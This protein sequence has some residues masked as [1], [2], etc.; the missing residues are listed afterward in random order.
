MTTEQQ[1]EQ[2]NPSEEEAKLD[3]AEGQPRSRRLA[4]KSVLTAV[5]VGVV[6]ISALSLSKIQR[7]EKPLDELQ[8]QGFNT[9][10]REVIKTPELEVGADEDK[11]GQIDQR[12]TSLSGRIDRGF[13][14]QVALSTDVKNSLAS[15]AESVRAIKLAVADLTESNHALRQRIDESIARL[16]TLIKETRK[17]KVAQKKPV[18][19]PKP[20]PAKTPPFHVDAIDVWDDMTYVAISQAGRVAFLKSGEQQS[21]WTVAG[22]DRLKGRVEFKGPHGQNHA[23]SLQR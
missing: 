13:E 2:I 14:A 11:V 19:R 10:T 23:I 21:G 4:Y 1:S 5:V 22:I 18:A 3:K 8:I 15:V 9:P 7:Q 17:R 6:V 20:T 12:L 16:N